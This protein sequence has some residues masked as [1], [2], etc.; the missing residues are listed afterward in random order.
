MYIIKRDGIKEEYKNSKIYNAILKADKNVTVESIDN[1]DE[2]VKKIERKLFDGISVAEIQ[3]IVEM[4]LMKDYPNIA[5]AYIEYRTS[6]DNERRKYLELTKNI[7]GL[8]DL[9]DKDVVES[10]ANKDAKVVPVQRDLLAGIIAKDWAMNYMLPKDVAEH[11][12]DG[13]IHIHDLDYS[14]FFPMY[15]CML[16]DVKSMLE[17]GF[18]LGNA[19]I[20]SPKSISVACSVVAQI[21]AQVAS[22]IYGGNTINGIDEALEPYVKK[23]FTKHY[24]KGVKYLYDIELPKEFETEFN[25]LENK[26][27]YLKAWEYAKDLTEKEVYDAFQ[28]LEYEI[29]TLFSANGQTP[30]STLGFGLS[31]SWEGRE[32]QKAILKNRIKGLG[33]EG[34]TPVFPKL[35]YVLKDGLNLKERDPNY[36]IKQIALECSTK[37]LYPDI[38]M[39]D[40]IV[41]FTGNFKYPMG[42]RSFLGKF[43]ENGVEINNGRFNLGVI[44]LNLVKVAI[45]SKLQKKDFFSFLDEKLDICKRALLYRVE[46][47]KGVKAKV[48]PILYENG[49]TGVYLDKED[50]I[51]Y[52]L[53]DGRSSISLGYIGLHETILYLYNEKMF[54]NEEM[55]ER[56]INILKHI[57]TR[58][59]TWKEEYSYG[60]SLYGTPSESLCYR[61]E[62]ILKEQYGEIENITDKTW[63]TNSFHLDVEEECTA[64]DKIDF[65]SRFQPLTTGGFISYVETNSM[66]QNPKALE[67]LWDYAYNKIGYFAINTPSDICFRCGFNG[68]FTPTDEGFVCPNCGNNDSKTCSCIRRVSGYLTEPSH[69]A[70]NKG[71]FDEMTSRFKHY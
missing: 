57:K 18:H 69:R 43:E 46:R 41:E 68:E 12:N 61:F 58:L 42:C 45:E 33:A 49:A 4:E 65:E 48:A 11:H 15:N 21:I 8:I 20:E 37:R 24:K 7:Q 31:S 64:F 9:S 40:K 5:R 19:T 13:Y 34:K 67:V 60:F 55:I 17:K 53:K 54:G 6:R 70:V 27:K 26:E 14:P 38:L 36:D 3:S 56:G 44:T 25:D 66:V 62:K 35:V 47:L 30:F 51:D 71:K 32:I 22:H 39:Y 28:A 59:D 10:N 23:S 1:L 50:E 16:I 2:I 29:N 52:L 63:I